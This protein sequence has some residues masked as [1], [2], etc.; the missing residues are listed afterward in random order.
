MELLWHYLYK[1]LSKQHITL[2]CLTSDMILTFVLSERVNPI[3]GKHYLTE[4][5]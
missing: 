1:P 3:F 2:I 5:S 4:G